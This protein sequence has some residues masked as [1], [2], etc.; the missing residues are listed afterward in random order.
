MDHIKYLLILF[1]TLL[2]TLIPLITLHTITLHSSP[3]TPPPPRYIYW[4]DLEQSRPRVERCHLDGSGREEI[5]PH[6]SAYIRQPGTITVDPITGWVYW[7]EVERDKLFHFTGTNDESVQLGD[8]EFSVTG[9]HV[10]FYIYIC[11]I[12][13]LLSSV[14]G[15][16]I[17]TKKFAGEGQIE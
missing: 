14:E 1:Y 13:I 5:L 11:H 3:L 7:A 9:T 12:I 15:K 6:L 2:A 8:V 10:Y 16:S 4:T 17:I